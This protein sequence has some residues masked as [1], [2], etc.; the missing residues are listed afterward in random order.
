M[1]VGEGLQGTQPGRGR[2]SGAGRQLCGAAVA[3][4]VA[5][6]LG[7]A[8]LAPA[9]SGIVVGAIAAGA[10]WARRLA[11]QLPEEDDHLLACRAV[12]HRF[13]RLG[14]SV[15][16]GPD[17]VAAGMPGLGTGVTSGRVIVEAF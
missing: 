4:S 15:S 5:R 10:G 3:A 8:T 16:I 11:R 6:G 2:V 17:Y 14:T 12:A 7:I 9:F 13:A 1:L